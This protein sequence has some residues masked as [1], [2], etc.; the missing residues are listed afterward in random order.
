[1]EQKIARRS[2]RA[3][4]HTPVSRVNQLPGSHTIRAANRRIKLTSTIHPC[5]CELDIANHYNMEA[6]L[7]DVGFDVPTT[8]D[9]LQALDLIAEFRPD[10]AVLDIESPGMDVFELPVAFPGGQLKHAGLRLFAVSG[11]GQAEDL[12][13]SRAPGFEQH[14][15]KPAT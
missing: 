11:Y 10:I 13:R 4:K 1:M 2:A 3:V 7:A 6:L 14:F 5:L 15:V 8:F 9:P 12:K